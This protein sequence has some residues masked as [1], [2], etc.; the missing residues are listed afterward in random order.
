MIMSSSTRSWLPLR[1]CEQRRLSVPRRR[2]AMALALELS[3]EHVAILRMVVDDEN[4]S[5]NGGRS[6]DRRDRKLR[7]FISGTRR[8]FLALA[9]NLAAQRQPIVLQVF[10]DQAEKRRRG[11][12][13]FGQIIGVRDM[14]GVRGLFDEQLG[15]TDDLI[16]R[17]PQVV[18][19][20]RQVRVIRRCVGH[21][22]EVPYVRGVPGPANFSILGS[23]RVSSMGFVS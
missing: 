22:E 9:D 16:Q 7:S 3:H 10:V 18:T 6:V 20:M 14:F 23:S 8:C 19:Q 13:N 21:G 2:Y 4:V 5:G 15:V 12:A 11:A 1:N 17:R